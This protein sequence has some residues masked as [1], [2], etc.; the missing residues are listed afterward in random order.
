MKMIKV[1]ALAMILSLPLMASA[2]MSSDDQVAFSNAVGK[3]D[4]STVKKY[5]DNGVDVNDTYFAWSAL[6][7]AAN[8]S[9]DEM[10]KF[11]LEQGADINYAH[12]ATRMTALSMAAFNG[13]EELVKFLISKGANVN[14]T[15]SNNATLIQALRNFDQNTTADLL[16]AAGAKE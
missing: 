13:D 16:V 7:M 11:L 14:I 4:I 5:L 6:Q 15:L 12:P 3:G 10:V 9:Q 8:H 1:F 2:E